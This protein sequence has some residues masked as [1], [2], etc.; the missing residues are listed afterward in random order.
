[1]TFRVSA[2]NWRAHVPEKRESK[3]ALKSVVV[4]GN[5]IFKI[6]AQQLQDVEAK[7]EVLPFCL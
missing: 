5:D 7:T 4:W 3:N 1:M 6:I 2:T